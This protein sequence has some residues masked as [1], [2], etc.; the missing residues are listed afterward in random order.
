MFM[1]EIF[2]S[3]GKCLS[4]MGNYKRR[5]KLDF[6]Y[7]MIGD[8]LDSGDIISRTYIKIERETSIGD[9]YN[10]FEKLIPKKS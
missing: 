8:E 1:V 4:S 5:I 2:P 10:K 6:V 3:T 9:V 7:K